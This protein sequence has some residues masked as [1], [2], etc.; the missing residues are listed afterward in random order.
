MFRFFDTAT[1]VLICLAFASGPAQS[2]PTSFTRADDGG[3]AQQAFIDRLRAVD[4]DDETGDYGCEGLF[5][6]C[7]SGSSECDII[8][9][10]SCAG[11]LFCIGDTCYCIYGG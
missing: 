11:D 1:A 8:V 6:H 3:E 7:D 4:P 9:S 10:N 5:C 2:Q